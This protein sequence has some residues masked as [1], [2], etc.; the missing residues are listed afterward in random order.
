MGRKKRDVGASFC[1]KLLSIF[2]R[3]KRI[4]QVAVVLIVI[5]NSVEPA[6]VLFYNANEN[7]HGYFELMQSPFIQ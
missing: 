3:R 4:A 7:S 6:T 5:S 1:R 2:S